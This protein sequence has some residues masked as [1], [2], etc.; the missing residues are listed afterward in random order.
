MRALVPLRWWLSLAQ[1][2]QKPAIGSEPEPPGNGHLHRSNMNKWNESR[3]T[4]IR[5]TRLIYIGPEGAQ[6][7]LSTILVG[8]VS[9]ILVGV[10]KITSTILVGVDKITIAIL[11]GVSK[12]AQPR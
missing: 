4:L 8:V 5:A 1:K 2:G 12:L 3:L 10:S 9:T 6:I 7:Y 11:V